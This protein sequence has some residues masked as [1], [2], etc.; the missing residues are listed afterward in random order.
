MQLTTLAKGRVERFLRTV[1]DQFEASA[2]ALVDDGTIKT[3]DDLNDHLQRWLDEYNHRPHSSTG[4]A[5][6]ELIGEV[7][8]YPDLRRLSEIFLWRETRLVSKRGEV[9]VGGNHYS[10]VRD[11]L[12]GT[13]VTVA[14]HPFDL[15]EVY[16]EIDRTFVAAKPALPVR[17]LEHPKMAPPT[18][19]KPTGPA[20]YVRGLKARD[21]PQPAIAPSAREV[22]QT[23]LAS[24]LAREL[25]PEEHDLVTAYLAR[26]GLVLGAQLDVRLCAFVRRHGRGQHLSRYLDAIWGEGR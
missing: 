25:R 3:V 23:A 7:R 18:K 11:D 21:K 19:K 9:S 24:A 4:N 14:Y 15:R 16:L 5:P 17:H 20:D 2:R 12:V 10:V 8:P 1:Q 6:L 13:K 22:V 26:P